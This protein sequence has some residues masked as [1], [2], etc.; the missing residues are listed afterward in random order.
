MRG[1]ESEK[2]KEQSWMKSEMPG[3]RNVL[4]D[5]LSSVCLDFSVSNL[6]CVYEIFN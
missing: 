5:P 6:V 1:S 4:A 2:P 3:E